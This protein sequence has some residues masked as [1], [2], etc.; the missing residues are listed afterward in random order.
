MTKPDDQDIQG[1]LFGAEK[2][3]EAARLLLTRNLYAQATSS[4]YY[5]VF[6]AARAALWSAGKNAKT[7]RG[8]AQLF[9]QEF[10]KTGEIETVYADILT[11]H[12]EKRELADYDPVDFNIGK[13]EVTDIVLDAEKFV[14]KMK[15]LLGT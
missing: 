5:A 8:L 15:E 3:L 1:E 4:A 10:I 14:Q 7:H 11:G 9:G 6:H 13:E 2:E 12:R